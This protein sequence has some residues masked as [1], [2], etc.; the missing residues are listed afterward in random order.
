MI[1][2]RLDTNCHLAREMAVP[3]AVKLNKVAISIL[4]VVTYLPVAAFAQTLEGDTRPA[5]IASEYV[6]RS[7]YKE[8]LVPVRVLGAVGKPGMYFVPAK[9]DLV[10]LLTLAGGM[11]SSAEGDVVVRKADESWSTLTMPGLAKR[12]LAYELDF[13][14]V[15]LE[16]A[17]SSLTLSAQDV[18]YVPPEEPWISSGT[19]RTVSFV[20]IVMGIVLTGILITQNAQK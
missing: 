15:M 8:G 20:S 1:A 2:A 16:G 18:V 12:N 10:K 13:N 6:Y 19:A 5:A 11:L 3:R 4:M 7:T 17:Y 14:H 9:T